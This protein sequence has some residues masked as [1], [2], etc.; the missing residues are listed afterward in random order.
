SVRLTIA[1]RMRWRTIHKRAKRK[2]LHEIFT[3][4]D[5]HRGHPDSSSESPV[6]L[7]GDDPCCDRARAEH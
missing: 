3:Q 7:E 6:F 2:T 1:K 5:R 4:R